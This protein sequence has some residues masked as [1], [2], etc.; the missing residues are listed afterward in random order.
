MTLLIALLL[1]HHMEIMTPLNVVL[2]IILWVGHL[3]TLGGK[4]S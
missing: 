3:S 2:V 1:M 4:S